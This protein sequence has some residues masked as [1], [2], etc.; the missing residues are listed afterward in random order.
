MGG[1][2]S[3]IEAAYDKH[4]TNIKL[5]AKEFKDSGYDP[6]YFKKLIGEIRFYE[7]INKL[8]DLN[9]NITE[10][11]DDEE[12][13]KRTQEFDKER[14]KFDEDLRKTRLGEVG[15]GILNM[16][17]PQT[18]EDEK[19]GQPNELK[20][21]CNEDGSLKGENDED[22]K[23]NLL[24]IVRN[25]LLRPFY[26]I[27]KTMGNLSL[28][29]VKKMFGGAKVNT[30]LEE[31]KKNGL[32]DEVTK[33]V[34]NDPDIKGQFE[35]TGGAVDVVALVAVV[36][37]IILY[38]IVIIGVI[39]VILALIIATVVIIA[40]V[41]VT[42]IIL[43]VILAVV[44]IYI[45]AT[46]PII[47][48]IM[49]DGDKVNER[50]ADFMDKYLDSYDKVIDGVFSTL[51]SALS[52]T[53]T[54]K[55]LA[56]VAT[57]SIAA[58]GKAY[59][60]GMVSIIGKYLSFVS[61]VANMAGDSGEVS[62]SDI[63]NAATT[64]S[65]TPVN[66]DTSNISSENL[67]ADDLSNTMDNLGENMERLGENAEQISALVGGVI[68]T[69]LLAS[70]M[71]SEFIKT[72]YFAGVADDI[73]KGTDKP[74]NSKKFDSTVDQFMKPENKETMTKTA[75]KM[76]KVSGLQSVAIEAMESGEK[77]SDAVNE[78]FKL[79]IGPND[80]EL[81]GVGGTSE[82]SGGGFTDN[83]NFKNIYQDLLGLNGGENWILI[84]LFADQ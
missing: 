20:M 33:M 21:F 6:K 10:A 9:N 74:K 80:T 84:N 56:N 67:K 72:F 4:F 23:K 27:S 35:K 38:A 18:E 30:V 61:S 59:I 62:K 11:K 25:M 60:S 24:F 65:S 54:I 8:N 50:Q 32:Y 81:T 13:K 19:N 66:I 42:I 58:L 70:D 3:K 64:S 37:I 82:I 76:S 40:M 69:G 28:Q 5:L 55:N 53:D 2:F 75:N 22:R 47:A 77:S 14:K 68:N 78:T 52:A 16:A 7:R 34:E 44:V 15:V 36:G 79:G 73:Q 57:T 49:K 48:Y 29:N 17:F 39:V 31:M 1:T 46:V 43:A 71:V 51:S 41:L 12:R 63:I 83:Y 45:V 26:L